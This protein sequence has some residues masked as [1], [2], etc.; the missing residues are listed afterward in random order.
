MGERE[1]WFTGKEKEGMSREID[2]KAKTFLNGWKEEVNLRKGQVEGKE[3]KGKEE[4][5]IKEEIS[6]DK[7]IGI[8]KKKEKQQ[9]E[10]K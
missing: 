8:M 5:E 9:K 7:R 2:R 1:K 6:D 10:R 3:R 4:K